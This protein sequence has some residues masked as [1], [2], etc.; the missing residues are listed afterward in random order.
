M[1]KSYLS[2]GLFTVFI[3]ADE[4]EAEILSICPPPPLPDPL[5]DD[6][7]GLDIIVQP[8]PAFL[9]MPSTRKSSIKSPS[10]EMRYRL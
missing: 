5:V 9:G 8:P 1:C 4:G 2:N 6:D 3:L 10:L 7:V